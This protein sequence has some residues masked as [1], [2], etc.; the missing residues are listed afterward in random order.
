MNAPM[1][2]RTNNPFPR[3]HR[4]GTTALF[5][6]LLGLTQP[7]SAVSGEQVYGETAAEDAVIFY[8]FPERPITAISV[9]GNMIRFDGPD[10]FEHIGVGSIGEG[11]VVCYGSARAYDVGADEFGFGPTLQAQCSGAK[12]TIRRNTADGKLSLLQEFVKSTNAAGGRHMRIKMTLKNNTG[13]SIA[14]V[15]LRRQVDF[16]IDTGGSKGT[17]EF[18]NWFGSSEIQSVFA[19]NAANAHPT[20]SHMVVLRHIIKKPAPIPVFSKTTSDILDTSCNP[21][22]ITANGPNFGDYGATLQYNVGTL[23]ANASFVTE[24]EYS[25]N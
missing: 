8:T 25:R 20:E 13:A 24:V 1:N 2:R 23:K 6:G 5:C 12:C 7:F 21:S 9:H 19:W 14:G 15:V 18:R 17:G 3:G 10:G 11:Y 16:D 22:N 4:V